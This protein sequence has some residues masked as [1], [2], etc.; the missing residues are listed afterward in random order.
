MSLESKLN[1]LRIDS[2]SLNAAKSEVSVKTYIGKVAGATSVRGLGK[3]DFCWREKA[4]R[5]TSAPEPER[6]LNRDLRSSFIKKSNKFS[7]SHNRY[8]LA[9]GAV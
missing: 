4:A 1:T 5:S 9:D 7:R 2:Y 3:A 6:C 8:T